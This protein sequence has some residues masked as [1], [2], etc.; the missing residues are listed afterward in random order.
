MSFKNKVLLTSLNNLPFEEY[1]RLLTEVNNE[2]Y[3]TSP[4]VKPAPGDVILYHNRSKPMDW[5]SD[6]FRWREYGRKQ[7]PKADPYLQCIYYKSFVVDKIFTRMAY[8]LL[9]DGKFP[10]TTIVRASPDI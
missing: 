6:Q 1:R 4:P 9:S 8:T 10:S 5:K 3:C 7:I 2:D